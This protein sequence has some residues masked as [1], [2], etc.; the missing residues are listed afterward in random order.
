MTPR[1]VRKSEAILDHLRQVMACE[2]I[3]AAQAYEL[4]DVKAPC[5][6]AARTYRALRDVVASL[7]D[8]RATTEDL[9]RAATLVAS[10]QLSL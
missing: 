9:E 2:L 1:A 8:D 6:V 3:V 5:P 7:D 4:R 10:P